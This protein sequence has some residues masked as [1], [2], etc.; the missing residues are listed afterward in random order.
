M[1]FRLHPPGLVTI[2]RR[3]SNALQLNDPA[4]SRDHAR[5]SFRPGRDNGGRAAGEWLL[6]DLGSTHGTWLNGVPIRSNREYHLRPGDLIVIGPWTFLVVDRS[7]SGR[8][9]TTLATVHDAAAIGTIVSRLEARDDESMSFEGLRLLQECSERIHAARS[10]GSVVEAALDAAIAATDFTRAAY[11]RP[12][13]ADDLVEV[14]SSRGGGPEA[15]AIPRLSRALIREASTG[16]PARLLRSPSVEG[17]ATGA[18][19]GD[20]I[21]ALCVP[22]LVESTL[23]GFLYLDTP[24]NEPKQRQLAGD[25]H[26]F[27]VGLARLAS[28]GVANLM[29][30]DIERRHE[31][32][33]A[34]LLAAAEAQRWLLPQRDGQSGPFA[35]VAETRQGQYAGGDFY[36]II[37]LSQ[38][39]LAV[40]LGD[41]GG[42]G[43]PVSVLV[44]ASQGFLHACMEA[45]GDPVRSVASINRLYVSRIAHSSFLKLW[46]GVFDASARELTYVSA[47]HGCAMTISTDGDYTLLA[48]GDAVSVGIKADA[49]FE[50]HR[51]ALTRG[52]RVLL[53]SDGIVDQRG[54]DPQRADR[55]DDPPQCFG[56]GRVQECLRSVHVRQDEVQCLF[57]AL[58]RH[59]G[60]AGPEDDATAVVVRW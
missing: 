56:I 21:V 50:P 10:E 47:G 31:R 43:I 38:E 52:M 1:S 42:K 29:R 26:A 57:E 55:D 34:E 35:Y 24:W 36:D 33:E 15:E 13:T 46:I 58:T 48:P 22:I 32:M 41:V 54:H 2:G 20:Q 18:P 49:L 5:L 17:A 8:P 27:L 3:S 7:T 6:G 16:S 23:V 12:M 11:L 30:L 19:A 14:V 28:L 25:V 53:L 60:T 44:S 9:G 37:P 59:A 39:R 45:W 40:V 4:V 51:V